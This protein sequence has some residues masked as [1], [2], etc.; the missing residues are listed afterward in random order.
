MKHAA[1]LIRCTLLGAL[2][3]LGTGCGGSGD[4]KSDPEGGGG[5][6]GGGSGGGST[7]DGDSTSS[8]SS[9]SA[10]CA[11]AFTSIEAPYAPNTSI[12]D[13]GGFFADEQGLVFS[14]LPD[15]TLDSY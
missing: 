1:R 8:T 5:S 6:A 12:E 3:A 9:T 11:G 14:A 13:W 4:A 2:V 10:A 15:S 7:G